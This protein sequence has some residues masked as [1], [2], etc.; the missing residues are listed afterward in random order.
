[1][2]VS[3]IG[4]KAQWP[5]MKELTKNFRLDYLRYQELLQ[6][7]RLRATGLSKDARQRLKRGEVINQLIVQDRNKPISI[8]EQII[9][10]TA[11]SLNILDK[12]SPK[13]IIKFKEGIY[14]FI[15]NEQPEVFVEMRRN[16][17]L[18]D[19]QKEIIKE[20]LIRF[21]FD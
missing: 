14:A 19:E 15:K 13:E 6:M 17:T 16:R 11:L 2:S 12:L 18:S 1:L 9:Y 8:E 7:T 3:R 20:S 4:S 10:L 5:A 21:F